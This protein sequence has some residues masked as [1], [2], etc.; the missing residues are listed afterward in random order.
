MLPVDKI[1]KRAKSHHV[2]VRMCVACGKREA[3]FRLVRFVRD[4]FDQLKMDKNRTMGG[5]GAYV[6]A[7][8]LCFEKAVSKRLFNRALRGKLVLGLIDE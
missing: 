7:S 8:K 2:P 3:S 1:S 5:R 4:G 6:C